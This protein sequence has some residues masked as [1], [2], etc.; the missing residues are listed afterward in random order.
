MHICVTRHLEPCSLDEVDQHLSCPLELGVSL[1]ASELE[2][3]ASD[4]GVGGDGCELSVNSLREIL[5][6]LTQLSDI[7]A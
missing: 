5:H 7:C 3:L 6:Q 2:L 1:F 4:L